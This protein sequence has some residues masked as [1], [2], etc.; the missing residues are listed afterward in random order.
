MH[1][2]TARIHYEIT[3]P[4]AILERKLIDTINEAVHPY[5]EKYTRPDGSL[6]WADTW[7]GSRD[8]MD[9]FYEAFTNF[10]Q[11]YSL[12]GGNHLL[13]A[14]DR[15]W[16]A[17]TRQLTRFGRIYREYERGYDQFHQS[18]SYIYFYH[19]CLAD[20][21]NPKL[22]DR[23]R[24]F[25][26]FYLNEFPDAPNYDPVHRIIRAP[27]T[28]SGGPAWGMSEDDS[29][30]SYNPGSGSMRVYGLPLTDVP[31]ITHVDDLQDPAKARAMGKAM[32]ER[33]REGDVGNN[34]NVNGLIMNAYLMTGDDKYRDWLLE[35]VG[36]WLDR[37]RENGGLMPDNVGLD[38]RVGAL[39]N[40]KWYGGLYG[41]TWPHGFHSLGLAA[42][43]AS[44][45]AYML[46]GD[47]GFFELPRG[48]I[49][50]L[51]EEGIDGHFD[52]MAPKMSLREH[53]IGVD[54]SLGPGRRTFFTPYRYG[55]QGWMDYQPMPV[56]YPL[57][58]WNVSEAEED[59]A[60]M[61]YLR[62]RS[63]YDWSAV[64][65][66]R[67]KGD[68]H[69][70]EPWLLYLRGENPDYPERML[71]AA[72]AQVCHRLAQI[73]ADDSDLEAGP[74]IHLWQQVQ[75][76]TTEALVQLTMGCPQVI[77]YGGIPNA[78]LRYYDA[79]RKRPGLPAD[80]A[81]L[82]D[83]IEPSRVGVHLVNLHHTETRR[84]ILQA[85]ALAEH[86]FRKASY[87]TTDTPYPGATGA[88]A[89]TR[90]SE[91]TETMPVDGSRLLVELPPATRIHLDLEM[92]RYVNRPR[93]E[94]A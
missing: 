66:F 6:I 83:R 27:H 82:V 8:G 20:P 47:P 18:E 80:T 29:Q 19:L 26:G 35:Y 45:N 59:R 39:H 52:E 21:T 44:N 70:D 34:L 92:A 68:M 5:I 23:A 42:I 25:A 49:D 2:I 60:R 79:D 31:G 77:Y 32:A 62:E 57:N 10:A 56:T 75:P 41:W 13:E 71:G 65:P 74:Y 87:D 94:T 51:L 73:R 38:G 69:H 4:W 30:L 50:R 15:H 22:N 63:G 16:D 9:D 86:A 88:Y 85:G 81:A 12:G 28:G 37:A 55:D 48:M 24:R 7:S 40:G 64:V 17:I 1:T 53:Y 90:T 46:S 91:R 36:A 54:R 61:D 76:V 43:T 58:V 89:A 14:A 67:D 33:F 93:Y 84:V 3:P 11:F 72:H 78:R